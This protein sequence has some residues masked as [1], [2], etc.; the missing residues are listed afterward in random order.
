MSGS[1]FGN[2]QF[3]LGVYIANFPNMP[4][5][6]ELSNLT[7]LT[8]GEIYAI[9][10]A[11]GNGWRKVFNVYAKLIYALNSSK[12]ED[13]SAFSRWQQYRDEAM[14][15]SGSN[16]ALLF[17]SPKFLHVE[18]CVKIICGRTYAK[19]LIKTG[20]LN[21]ELT[22][23]DNE[24]AIDEQNHVIVC[25]YFDYRQLSNKKIDRLIKLII[26]FKI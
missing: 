4:E 5:Y 2:N 19:A 7:P 17:S 26:S 16:I 24:F 6:Q 12:I 20:A 22:W 8:Q 10:Q 9:G 18:R 3:S 25:P 15:Q 11:C 21:A 23:L 14:L 1:G 13:V